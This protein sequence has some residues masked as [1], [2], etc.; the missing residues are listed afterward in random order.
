MGDCRQAVPFAVAQEKEE[1]MKELELYIHI[2]FCIQKCRYCDFLSGPADDASKYRY[3]KAL[4]REIE[5]LPEGRESIITT[6]FFGGGT[7]SVL[8]GEWTARILETLKKRFSFAADAEITTEANPGTVD[9]EKLRIWR[10][11][12]INRISFGCQSSFHEE[13]QMLG[14]IHT[15]EDFLESYALA[16][17]RGFD[18]INIDLMSGLPGQKL[19]TWET[20]LHRAAELKPEH[21]SAY[22]LIV[23]EGTPFASMNLDL[24]DEDTERMMYS[25]TREILAGYGYGRYEISNYALQGRE[26][27]HNIGY[28]IRTPYIGL[29]L[30]AS[31]MFGSTRFTNTADMEEYLRN[32]AH[33]GRLRRNIEHLEKKDEIEETMFLGLRLARGVDK[34]RFEKTFGKT[35]REI[36]A[37]VLDKYIDL[38][39]LKETEEAVFLTEDGISV[40]NAVM[41]EFLLDSY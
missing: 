41:A 18:N 8:P 23:E 7:P 26:C 28:W 33:P 32:S 5:S 21:I 36:Y 1:K 19:K 24:P 39:L 10:E 25:R 38:G 34:R 20:T 30:G 35:V 3:T 37:P 14:R 27:R 12:G 4:I 16:R 17:E 9:K 31:S 13:L 6:V 22:S 29:G 11:S 2:P 40:S 15:W